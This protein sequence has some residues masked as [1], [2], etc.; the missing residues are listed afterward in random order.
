VWGRQRQARLQQHYSLLYSRCSRS[1]RILNTYPVYRERE[2]WSS[3]YGSD[4]HAAD[5]PCFKTPRPLSPLLS[6]SRTRFCDTEDASEWLCYFIEKHHDASFTLALESLGDPL[7]QGMTE[8]AAE[9]MWADA[10]T[11]ITQQ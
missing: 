3:F 4:L 6:S 8:T 11:D 1:R 7:V 5:S 9:A 2:W 10:N